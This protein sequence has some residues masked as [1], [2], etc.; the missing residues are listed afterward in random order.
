MRQRGFTLIEVLITMLVLA[1]GLTG[2][3]AVVMGSARSGVKASD[4]NI[5]SI[6][7]AEAIADIEHCHRITVPAGSV[8][9]VPTTTYGAQNV[10]ENEVGLYIET[11]DS[12]GSG[13]W[14]NI[15]NH[16]GGGDYTG[17]Y[18]GATH[19][20]LTSSRA[21]SKVFPNPTDPALPSNILLWPFSPDPRYYGG[22]LKKSGLSD[23]VAYRVGYK[24]ERHPQWLAGQFSY[25]GVYV[26]TLVVY[27]MANPT[28]QPSSNKIQLEQI[29]DPMVTYLYARGRTD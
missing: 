29:S 20:P 12:D 10:Q 4:R 3:L 19:F 26:L 11:V 15:Q 24:L 23:G 18:V 13:M 5:A 25:D 6:V 14:P 2:A 7:L 17:V 9:P 1:I 16:G 8:F 21:S 22:P 28:A 27:K